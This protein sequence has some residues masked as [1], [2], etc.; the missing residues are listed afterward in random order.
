MPQVNDPRL[1][2]GSVL[3]GANPGPGFFENTRKD[4]VPA[5][6]LHSGHMRR[7]FGFL[8][9]WIVLALAARS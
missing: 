8:L 3:T 5:L 4:D 1:Y 7:I 9:C 6:T 2:T